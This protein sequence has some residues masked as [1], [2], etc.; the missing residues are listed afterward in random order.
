MANDDSASILTDSQRAWL[1]GEDVAHERQMRKRIYKRVRAAITSDAELIAD[2]FEEGELNENTVVKDFTPSELTEGISSLVTVLY[3]LGDAKPGFAVE[4]AIQTGVRR[5]KKGYIASLE[6]KIEREGIKSLTI[7]E[8]FDLQG[9][10]PDKYRDRI[11]R[12]RD[13]IISDSNAGMYG[14]DD[15]IRE[16][17]DIADE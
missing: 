8:M 9:A 1:E 7:T 15:N 11:N 6:E 14:P 16:E 17:F 13:Q 2:A 10:K 3:L 12:I 4:G 5:G